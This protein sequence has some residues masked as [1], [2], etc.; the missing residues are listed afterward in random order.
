MTINYYLG[1]DLY[2]K[3]F[4]SINSFV[5]F[6]VRNCEITVKYLDTNKTETES[7]DVDRKEIFK[8][9]NKFLEYLILATSSTDISIEWDVVR[10][11]L[12]QRDN[13]FVLYKHYS[14]ADIEI[15]FE[16]IIPTHTMSIDEYFRLT[17]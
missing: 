4:E 10:Y 16:P 15:V 9:L 8:T 2:M 12:E 6:K 13:L 7:I 1:A 3:I 5:G 17:K 14:D 11:K